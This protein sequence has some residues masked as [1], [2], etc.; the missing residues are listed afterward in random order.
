MLAEAGIDP[1]ILDLLSTPRRAGAPYRLDTREIARRSMVTASAISQRL[2][3][4]ERDGLIERTPDPDRS[5]RVLVTLTASGLEV[6]DRYVDAI[7]RGEAALLEELSDQRL[8]D[9]SASLR[10]LMDIMAP[11]AAETPRTRVGQS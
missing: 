5:R 11:L 6:V 8:D 4:A 3:R 9:L 7:M 2:Q 1:A 10:E